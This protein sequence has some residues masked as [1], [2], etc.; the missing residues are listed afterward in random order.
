MAGV[1]VNRLDAGV[2]WVAADFGS[3]TADDFRRHFH[4]GGDMLLTAMVTHGYLIPRPR[5]GDFVLSDNGR[6]RER[7]TSGVEV[8]VG[9]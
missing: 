7:A 6:R 1:L 9:V 8:R 3:T 5:E 2:Q 4:P